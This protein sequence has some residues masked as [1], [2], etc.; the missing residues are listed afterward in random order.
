MHKLPGRMSGWG[1]AGWGCCIAPTWIAAGIGAG[2]IGAIRGIAG[3][4]KGWGCAI[5]GLIIYKNL[6]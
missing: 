5:I 1:C 4:I 6:T 3:V 2:T